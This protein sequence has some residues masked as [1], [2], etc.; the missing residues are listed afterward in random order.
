MIY[1][2]AIAPEVILLLICAWVYFRPQFNLADLSFSTR[3]LNFRHEY[4]HNTWL[5]WFALRC[6][7]GTWGGCGEPGHT[8][9]GLCR[10]CKDALE[11]YRD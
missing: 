1:I 3:G 5:A 9:C 4:W 2:L 11:V 8:F 10:Q 6:S 7:C